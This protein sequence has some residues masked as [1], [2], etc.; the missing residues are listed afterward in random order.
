MNSN[1]YTRSRLVHMGITAAVLVA[2]YLLVRRLS[3]V[4][5]PFLI[6]W[7]IAY[8]LYPIVRFFQDRCKLKYRILSVIATL[9][10]IVGCV[11]GLFAIIVP[12]VKEE[13]GILPEII[14]KYMQQVKSHAIL[15]EG[16]QQ[17]YQEWLASIDINYLLNNPDIMNIV[18][19]AMPH[20]WNIITSSA[21][22]VIGLSVV[23]VCLM[24]VVFIL[25]DYEKLS[26]WSS[27]IPE[28][29]RA[30]TE[31]IMSD[32]EL[33]MNRYFRGQ[34]LIA[35]IVGVLFAIGFKV[36]GLPLG[37][38]VG[39]F[40][41]ILNLVPYLQIVGIIPCVLLG[42]LQAVETGRPLW[43]VLLMI[44]VVFIV[45]QSIQDFLLTPRIMGN[46]TGMHPA[47]ILL[48]LSIWGSLLGVAGMIIA[49]PLTTLILSYYRRFVLKERDK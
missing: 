4:L 40:I 32:V 49:L 34:S 6:S 43:M 37:I 12:I 39:L 30:L 31:E 20:L 44:L 14:G 22:M 11:T 28:K 19:Q 26:N 1:N 3:G 41:G 7:L 5:V 23:F 24:Y 42:V 10:L 18:K 2:L 29:Y 38:L 46:V 21:S 48:S 8:I 25:L 15:P 35:L 33:N 17:Q 36:I 45:V 47:A 9:L 16:L 27:L 13:I